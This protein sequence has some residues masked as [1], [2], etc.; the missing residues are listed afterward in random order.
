MQAIQL[1]KEL[2]PI[3]PSQ[4]WSLMISIITGLFTL[5]AAFIGFHASRKVSNSEK[6]IDIAAA[7]LEKLEDRSL[8][9]GKYLSDIGNNIGLDWVA[10]Q[11]GKTYEYTNTY[12][13]SKMNLGALIRIYWPNLYEKY[14]Q[15]D[16]IV[17]EFHL[18]KTLHSEDLNKLDSIYNNFTT[19]QSALFNDLM[20]NVDGA[21][22]K[23]E[24]AIQ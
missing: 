8:L 14:Q 10:S 7:R 22:E 20:Q 16:S 18:A 13:D 24:G 15:Y 9:I 11:M 5:I 21:R 12:Q 19:A 4:L 1:L 6:K 17:Y 3:I 23:M 2:I